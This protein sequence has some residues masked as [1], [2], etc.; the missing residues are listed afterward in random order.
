M[1]KLIKHKRGSEVVQNI[2]VLAAMGAIAIATMLFL[3]MSINFAAETARF[4][5]EA[6][7]Y[8][9]IDIQSP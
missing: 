9:A 7:A 4:A 3:D 8:Q 1:L 5:L 6:N 2:L